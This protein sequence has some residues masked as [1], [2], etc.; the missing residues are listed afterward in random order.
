MLE[1]VGGEVHQSAAPVRQPA[2]VDRSPVDVCPGQGDEERFGL[3]VA[4]AQGGGE[5]LVLG[6]GHDPLRQSGQDT[7]RAHLQPAYGAGVPGPCHR[8]GETYRAAH[9]PYPVLGVLDVGGQPGQYGCVQL[10]P[11][12][13]VPELLQHR[14][15]QR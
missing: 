3:R 2:P 14:V 4:R 12:D 15:H 11:R 9:V 7:A 13:G 10:Q 8:V 6:L 5:D 1:G